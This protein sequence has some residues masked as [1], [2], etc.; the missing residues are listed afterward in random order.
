MSTLYTNTLALVSEMCLPN[1][2]P[3]YFLFFV[4]LCCFTCCFEF[5]VERGIS[6]ACYFM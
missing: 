3:W 2:L 4:L 6:L 1:I 5:D